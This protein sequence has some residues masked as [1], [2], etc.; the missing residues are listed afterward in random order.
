MVFRGLSSDNFIETPG[1]G[2]SPWAQFR[3]FLHTSGVRATGM[4]FGRTSWLLGRE[5][6]PSLGYF[7]QIRG[8]A[9]D[10]GQG[11]AQM[12]CHLDKQL[13]SPTPEC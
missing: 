4:M 3:I 9:L 1:A 13:S 7:L 8:M 2:F 12:P 11:L 5:G 6:Q 10:L